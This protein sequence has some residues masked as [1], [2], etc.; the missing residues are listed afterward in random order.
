MGLAPGHLGVASGHS[1]ER[2]AECPCPFDHLF[3][4]DASKPEYKRTFILRQ[5]SHLGKWEGTYAAIHGRFRKIYVGNA[6]CQ[7]PYE[8]QASVRGRDSKQVARFGWE[9]QHECVPSLGVEGS[10]SPDVLLVASL[11][12]EQGQG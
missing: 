9:Y 10:Q 6:F 8:V 2:A 4:G 7:P 5:L 12:H 11:A 3:R 1:L